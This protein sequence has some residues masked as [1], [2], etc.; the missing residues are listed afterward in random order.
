[1]P[2]Y[3]VEHEYQT[4]LTD[5]LHNEEVRRADPC[6]AQYGVTWKASYIASDRLKQICEFEAVNA[7]QVRSAL[8]SAD[9]PFARC[10]QADKYTAK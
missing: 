2:V 1:M 9:V 5:E 3:V 8:R 7:E 4:P 6:L 10:W